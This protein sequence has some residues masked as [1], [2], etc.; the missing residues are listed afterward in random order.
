MARPIEWAPIG[1]SSEEV[2]VLA[3][4]KILKEVV[5]ILWLWVK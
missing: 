5:N 3:G 4:H 1:L 2:A